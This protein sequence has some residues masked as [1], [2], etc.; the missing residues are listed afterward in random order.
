[1]DPKVSVLIPLYNSASYIADAIKSVLNQSWQNLEVIIVDDGSTDV[2]LD[3]AEKFISDKVSIYKQ[4][5]KGAC[6]ARNLAFEHAS[7][8]YIQYLDADDILHPEKISTQVALVQQYGKHVLLSAKWAKFKDSTQLEEVL[9]PTRGIDKD[10]LVPIDW[11]I[12]S[13]NGLGFGAVHTWLTPSEVVEKAGPWNEELAINQDGEFFSRVILNVKEIRHVADAKVYYRTGNVHSISQQKREKK[14]AS[15]LKSFTLYEKNLLP[16]IDTFPVRKALHR[17]YSNF[18]YE[19]YPEYPE[20][21][22]VAR[23]QMLGLGFESIQPKTGKVFSA[24]SKIFG[25][26]TT[27]KL[28]G[29][30]K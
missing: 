17:N 19:H 12:D 5:N 28:R 14:A 13:W 15:L 9:F 1:M 20:L 2:S 10:Y 8:D 30:L 25:A 21:T 26:E 4:Q 3:I 16:S 29:L 24:V 27:L 7:G 6:A 18:I 11:L 23:Q 22:A